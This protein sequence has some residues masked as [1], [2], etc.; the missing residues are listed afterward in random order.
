MANI[1]ERLKL[2]YG[3]GAELVIEAPPEGGSLVSI[4]IPYKMM[5]GE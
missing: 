3:A 2:L 4:R 1:R 5:E